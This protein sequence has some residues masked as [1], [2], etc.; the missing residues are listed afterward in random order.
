MYGN[1]TDALL[2]LVDTLFALYIIVVLLRILMAYHADFYNPI[3]QFV[4]PVTQPPVGLLA[5]VIP[6]WG[7]FDVAAAVFVLVLCF[8]NIQVDIWLY[9]LDLRAQPLMALWWSVLKAGVLL[10]N[11]YFFTILVQVLVSWLS[12]G[13]HSPATAVL[14]NLNEPLLRPVRQYLPP[15]GGL[16]ISPLVVII[17]LQVVSRLLPLPGLFR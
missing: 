9:P 7:R 5:R 4:Q 8:V 12:P 6:R 1:A 13:T 11:L 16:D 10:C 17:A 15:V 3:W 14:W 2:F